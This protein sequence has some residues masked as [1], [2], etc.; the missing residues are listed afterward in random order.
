MAEILVSDLCELSPA[1]LGGLFSLGRHRP[2][3][4]T[5]EELNRSQ[6][7][8][9]TP[10]ISDCSYCSAHC[11]FHCFPLFLRRRIFCRRRKALHC[12]WRAFSIADRLYFSEQCGSADRRGFR[13]ATREHTVA[14]FVS[15][16]RGAVQHLMVATVRLARIAKTNPTEKHQRFQRRR[17][18]TCSTASSKRFRRTRL[19]LSAAPRRAEGKDRRGSKL[20]KRS[21]RSN[22]DEFKPS[23]TEIDKTNPTEKGQ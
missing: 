4:T 19:D 16:H 17:S 7:G 1:L 18:S 12:N 11:F 9:S 23:R 2:H 20:V 8:A 10:R 22:A 6:P 14:S 21:R 3:A 5:S 15:H 13:L